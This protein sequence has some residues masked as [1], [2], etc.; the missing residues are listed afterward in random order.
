[1]NQCYDRIPILYE[2]QIQFVDPFTR[3]AHPAA[4]LQNRT[5]RIIN[6]FHFDIDQ[7]DSWCTLTPGNDHQEKPAV[8]GPK[9]V[10]PVPVHY[11]PGSQDAGMYSRSELS[12][13]FWDSIS[14]FAAS[15]NAIRKFWQKLIVFSN[16]NKNPD[17]FLY[18]APCTDLLVDNLIS[19]GYFEDRYLDIFGPVA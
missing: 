15:P 18:Y 12:S 19:P 8:F 16:N 17:S 5:D 3:Q 1:M 13:S 6:L 10:S 9:D 11:F 14:I 7:E 2:D 4:N